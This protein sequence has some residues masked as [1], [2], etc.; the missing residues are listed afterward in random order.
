M[1]DEHMRCTGCF[2]GQSDI[3]R[4]TR[5]LE[6]S[7]SEETGGDVRQLVSSI[8]ELIRAFSQGFPLPSK[9]TS[10]DAQGRRHLPALHDKGDFDVLGRVES[11]A[12]R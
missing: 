11:Q 2:D 6:I 9:G 8:R 7:Q 1:A 5:P 10:R 3:V 4:V 12:P